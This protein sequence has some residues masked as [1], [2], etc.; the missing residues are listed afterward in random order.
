MALVVIPSGI[1]YAD[2]ANCP[3]VAGLYAA[4]AGMVVFALFTSS[5]H[6]I[7]GPDAAIAILVG[8][9][10]GPMSAGEPGQAVV[11]STWLALLT[12]LILLVA[13]WLRLGGIAEFLSSPVMLGFMNGAA[14][15]IIGSQI[16]KLCG[17][18]LKED[19]TLPRFLE[20]A[21]QLEATHG[22]TLACGLAGM[23]ILAGLRWWRPQ[24]PG[25]IVVFV[26]ALIAGRCVDFP[27]QG[28]QV[29]G[30][31]QTSI[32]TPVPPE[33]S[34]ADIGQLITSA[35]GLALLI[36]PEGIVLGRAMGRRHNYEIRP[37]QEFSRSGYGKPVRWPV[38]QLCGRRESVTDAPQL[39][40]WRPDP[41][42]EFRCR[43]FAD[44]LYVLSRIVD[45]HSSHRGHCRHPDLHRLDTH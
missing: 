40:L 17:I 35:L 37:D 38:P 20:W 27:A 16:G 1:A 25:V 18:R 30:T 29:I 33:L 31:I 19:N 10:I 21:T 32:P 2:L 14:V 24:V 44:W 34:L 23:V 5:R 41:D 9:A 43:R 13:A 4:L 8:A 39:R 3:P 15:V 36:F 45:F 42:G 11:L 22:P 28:V 6:L 12:A 7:V 26:L